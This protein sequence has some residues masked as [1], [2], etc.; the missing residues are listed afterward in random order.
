MFE[1]I[2]VLNVSANNSS[3]LIE[4]ITNPDILIEISN[5]ETVQNGFLV[6]RLVNSGKVF[7][8]RW[9]QAGI[10][11]NLIAVPYGIHEILLDIPSPL[12]PFNLEIIPGRFQFKYSVKISIRVFNPI[13]SSL[14][15]KLGIPLELLNRIPQQTLQILSGIDLMASADTR[16]LIQSIEATGAA[17]LAD[18]NAQNAINAS[19]TAAIV[20]VQTT[21]SLT[22]SGIA[23]INTATAQISSEMII[24]ESFQ[25]PSTAFTLQSSGLYH[26]VL[27]LIKIDGSNGVQLSLTDNGGDEQGFSQLMIKYGEN[28]QKVAIE[29]TASQK[30]DSSYPLSLLCQ[31]RKL[32]TVIPPN[33]PSPPLSAMLENGFTARLLDRILTITNSSGTVAG[34]SG[35]DIVGAY[36][37]GGDR[38]YAQSDYGYFSVLYGAT[39]SPTWA[40]SSEADY[41]LAVSTG[42]AIPN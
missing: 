14:A 23:A 9:I 13:Y 15:G 28:T 5:N 21:A 20:A 10:S 19:N 34:A 22:N 11:G 26:A 32:T 37:R 41:Q 12:N 1:Q 31:G 38:I 4:G 3:Q 36:F 42:T 17:I 16:N 6:Q 35:S 30:N 27:D 8:I 40:L 24:N 2:A 25:V 29:F 7:K 33:P 18:K 39:P